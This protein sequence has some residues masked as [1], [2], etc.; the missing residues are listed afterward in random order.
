MKQIKKFLSL[1]L[2]IVV[3]TSCTNEKT[4]LKK[5]NYD[6]KQC[7]KPVYTIEDLNAYKKLIENN[8][9]QGYNCSR[10]VL[11]ERKDYKKQ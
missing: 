8:E 2:L 9:I 10:F 4:E 6:I 7:N 11:Y 3:F 1:A 5:S